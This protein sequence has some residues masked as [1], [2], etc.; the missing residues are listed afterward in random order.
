MTDEISPEELEQLLADNLDAEVPP[1]T[2]TV[3]TEETTDQ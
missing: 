3:N 1:T 2:Q